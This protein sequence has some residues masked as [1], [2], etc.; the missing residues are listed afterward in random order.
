MRVTHTTVT[1]I[2]FTLQYFLSMQA[3]IHFLQISSN[4]YLLMNPNF[5]FWLW[6]FSP[7]NSA[8]R[9]KLSSSF[10]R[11]QAADS[12]SLALSYSAQTCLSDTFMRT[13]RGD[14]VTGQDCCRQWLQP[15][16]LPCYL[17][18]HFCNA[19]Y[20]VHCLSE[21]LPG[22]QDNVLSHHLGN[23][24]WVGLLSVGLHI[25]GV[26]HC[27]GELLCYTSTASLLLVLHTPRTLTWAL[28]SLSS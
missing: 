13:S 11:W 21:W 19:S 17:N 25:Q 8:P 24:L 23:Y 28:Q 7:D 4:W 26:S 5:L 22:W 14:R 18:L 27:G 3:H 10:L 9:Y 20:P 1:N 2:H 16:T 12:H 6:T 15:L